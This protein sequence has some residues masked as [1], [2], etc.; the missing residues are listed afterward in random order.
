[1]DRVALI[2]GAAGQDGVYLA[3]L[4]GSQGYRVVGTAPPGSR[5]RTRLAPYLEGVELTEV[6][7][8]DRDAMW[9]LLVGVRPDELYNLA[10][11]SSVGSSW[12][13]TARVAEVNGDAV[14]GLRETLNRYRDAFGAAPRFFQA[15]SS[16]IFGGMTSPQAEHTRYDPQTPYGAAKLVAHETTVAARD[17]DELFACNGILFN[18]ES[19]LR[20]TSFVSRRITHAVASIS[21]DRADELVLGNLEVSRDW[22]AAAD[23]VRAMWL[24]LQRDS[25]AD[26]VIATGVETT[27]REVVELAFGCVGI[28]D[29]WRFVRADPTRMRPADVPRTVGDPS[30]AREVL[31]WAATTAL[32]ALVRQMVTVDR[33]RLRS[34][35]E[36]SLDY[37]SSRA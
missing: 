6:D 20:P 10:A 12:E 33:E 28:D 24:M 9:E 31:G 29:P 15:S 1:V 2:T 4:L 11:I 36:E 13:D 22:G 21:C 34:G 18:H 5:Q 23:H 8:C 7:V 14:V 37:L 35:V 16:E 17:S 27:L 26:Y 30:R 19:P 32:S 3:R 25:A